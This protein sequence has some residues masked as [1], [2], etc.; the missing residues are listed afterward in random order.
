MNNTDI[1]FLNNAAIDAL[2]AGDIYKGFKILSQTFDH[3][4]RN[5]HHVHN[6]TASGAASLE[7]C[8]QDCSR[9]LQTT[10][11][12]RNTVCDDSCP[13]LCLNFLRMEVPNT[14]EDRRV[15]N[16]L[17]NCAITWALRYN[18]AI[19]YTIMGFQRNGGVIYFKRALRILYPI[20]R[21]VV[22]QQSKSPFWT[23]LKLSILNNEICMQREVGHAVDISTSVKAMETLLSQSRRYL[24]P[25]DVKK[26]YLSMQF[27]N[28][29]PSVA[30]AA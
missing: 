19:V 13:F 6:L 11:H 30:P 2:H 24:D 16:Q 15:V 10:L 3:S 4:S 12:L 9:N 25:I 29:C 22:L 17:C 18:L 1:I 23:N 5:R 7:F 26:Y 14:K 8:L 21:Q 27:L 20:K 28:L